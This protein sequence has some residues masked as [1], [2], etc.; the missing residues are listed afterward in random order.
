[1]TKVYYKTVD[2]NLR[3]WHGNLQYEVGKEVSLP[4]VK[5]PQLCSNTVLH[6][7]EKPLDA[8]RYAN[9]LNC[10]LLEVSGDEVI[11]EDDKSGFFSLTVIREVPDFEKDSLYGFSYNEA[12]HPVNPCEIISKP[13]TEDK[14]NLKLWKSAV[15]S[16]DKFLSAS[17]SNIVWSSVSDYV[18]ASVRDL[19]KDSVWNLTVD[20]VF[21]FIRNSFRDPTANFL[22]GSIKFSI[23][24]SID[25]S[26]SNS[27]WAYIGYLFPKINKWAHIDHKEGEYPFQ[28]GV[29]LWKRGFI[30]VKINGK[31]KLYNLRQD[32]ILS[33]RMRR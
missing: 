15:E 30:P 21:E 32:T 16:L 18:G 3:S 13:T 7:S 2:R 12:L 20:S 10:A 28:P 27:A 25:E 11:H 17:I 9:V 33:I 14:K 6:A 26:I 19:V 1:M 5:E 23:I 8:L 29:E 31:W 22:D 4:V 24:N